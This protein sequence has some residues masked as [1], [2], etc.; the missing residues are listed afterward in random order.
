MDDIEIEEINYF[1]DFEQDEGGWEANGYVRI[2]NILPQTFGVVLVTYGKTTTVERI[3]LNTKNEVDIPIDLG[4]DVDSV[5]L[6]V[7]GTTR[8]TREKA[9]YRYKIVP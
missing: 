4:G 1:S 2:E 6:I 7:M 5:V 9:T 8:Y 3:S